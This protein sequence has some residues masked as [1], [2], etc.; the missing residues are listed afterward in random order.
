M[1][2]LALACLQLN[3]HLIENDEYLIMDSDKETCIS[4][5]SEIAMIKHF[6]AMFAIK[7]G[8]ME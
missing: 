7:T 6:T 1:E 4:R 2:D 5:E 8:E 3:N